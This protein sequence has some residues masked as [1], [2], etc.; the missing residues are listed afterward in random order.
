MFAE[1][2]KASSGVTLKAL[3]R[4]PTRSVA[5]TKQVVRGADLST[6]PQVKHLI[7]SDY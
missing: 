7:R 4:Q 1:K 5:L 3:M 6:L 2:S